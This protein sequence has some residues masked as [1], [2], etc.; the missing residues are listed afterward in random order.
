[1]CHLLAAIALETIG[2]VAEVD[3]RQSSAVRAKVAEPRRL[4]RRRLGSS[5]LHHAAIRAVVGVEP[6]RSLE[7][8]DL[9]PI[10]GALPAL[11]A[12]PPGLR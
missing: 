5:P 6:L 7:G 9:L 1:M 3:H 4:A 10:F 11:S 12:V 2:I 8:S